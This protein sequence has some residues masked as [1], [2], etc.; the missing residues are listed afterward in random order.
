MS[1]SNNVVKLCERLIHSFESISKQSL[2]MVILVYYMAAM[3]YLL[4]L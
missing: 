1:R 3:F 4:Y 2:E